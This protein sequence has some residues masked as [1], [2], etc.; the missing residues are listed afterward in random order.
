[1]RR[2]ASTN[3]WSSAVGIAHVE[4]LNAIRRELVLRNLR[5]GYVLDTSGHRISDFR[6]FLPVSVVYVRGG[7]D[8]KRSIRR[9][10]GSPACFRPASVAVTSLHHGAVEDV[11]S[12]GISCPRISPAG[13]ATVWTLA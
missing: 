10:E 8:S 12:P 4:L 13:L 5:L 11:V 6:S 9:C 3:F 1:M 7:R 2:L